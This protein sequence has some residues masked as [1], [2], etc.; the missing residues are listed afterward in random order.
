MQHVSE[1]EPDLVLD[2]RI[3]PCGKILACII[4][5]WQDEPDPEYEPPLAVKLL[6]VDED[7]VDWF[8]EMSLRRPW[9][10]RH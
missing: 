8:E 1:S 4:P 6:E 2:V 3:V 5:S 9:E 7:V 10:T